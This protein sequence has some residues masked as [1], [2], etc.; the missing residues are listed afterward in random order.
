[1]DSTRFYARDAEAP[2]RLRMH[3]QTLGEHWH[4]REAAL[5]AARVLPLHT[6]VSRMPGNAAPSRARAQTTLRRST[7]RCRSARRALICEPWAE[8]LRP[9][10]AYQAKFSLPYALVALLV[11]GDVTIAT[12][13]GPTQARRLR[14]RCAR[15]LVADGGRRLPQPLWRAPHGDHALGREA[16]RAEVADVRGT[17]GR[18]FADGE[19]LAKF[20]RL[21]APRASGR[22]A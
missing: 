18:P 7:A 19:V 3:L 10:S 6:A 1:M 5:K 21:C 17:P 16:T 8:K 15:D 20:Y 12:F 14:A 9:S 13:E 4:L 2:A 11:D 22:R